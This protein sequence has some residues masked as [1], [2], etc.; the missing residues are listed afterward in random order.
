MPN[1]PMSV[2]PVYGEDESGQQVLVDL[3]VS[4]GAHAG[5]VDRSGHVRDWQFDYQEDSEGRLHHIF[6]DVELESEQD[7]LSFNEDAYIDALLESNPLIREA[8][9]WA[10]ENLPGPVLDQYNDAIDNGDLKQLNEAI[11]WLVSEYQSAAPTEEVQEVEEE[12]EVDDL[13]E[14]E[15]EILDK[16]VDLLSQQEPEGEY[17]ADQ[18]Q[19]AVHQAEESGDETYA[20][21]AAATAAF[22]AGDVTAEE[23]I[24]YCLQNTDLKDLARVYKHLAS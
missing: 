2:S 19:D 15:Q 5:A 20:M 16:T 4:T 12:S 10:N 22:H 3:D 7:P 1:K 8:Q 6:Q 9:A 11:E 13:S 18:W 24:N 14:E 21:V 23:A 17:V